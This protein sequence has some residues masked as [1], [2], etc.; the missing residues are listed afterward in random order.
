[1]RY[2][3]NNK[4]QGLVEFGIVLAFLVFL[5]I[6]GREAMYATDVLFERTAPV[7]REIEH[8][9]TY[10]VSVPIKEVLSKESFYR[11][12]GESGLSGE[13]NS[14]G[15]IHWMRGMIRSGWIEKEGHETD[16]ENQYI[17]E[18]S[19]EL[20]ASQWSY[21]NGLGQN[22]YAQKYY[23]E[24]KKKWIGYGH[25]T[26]D[27]LDLMY[28][29]NN[30]DDDAGMYIGDMGLYWTVQPL[31]SKDLHPVSN[32]EKQNYSAEFVLQYFYSTYTERYYVILGQVW[33]QQG[34]VYNRVNL[35]GLHQQYFK[36]A[37]YFVNGCVDGFATL[38]EAKELFE[39]VRRNN[40]Y[41]VIFSEVGENDICAADYVIV[42]N[43]FVPNE[44]LYEAHTENTEGT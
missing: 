23:D 22:Y 38:A 27:N 28:A 14:S 7:L 41:D 4:G 40:G 44:N 13:G 1:M 33:I 26:I 43:R 8:H 35:G 5:G 16:A 39:E 20:G 29:V 32:H 18:L 11:A 31:G 34:D 36:P 10:D 19:D 12:Y 6:Y 15:K 37:G 21:L 17:K 25:N 2:I 30:L 3:N 42:N 24:E 9:R